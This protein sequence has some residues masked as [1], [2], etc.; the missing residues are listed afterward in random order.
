MTQMAER[1]YVVPHP[2]PEVVSRVV[3]DIEVTDIQTLRDTECKFGTVHE[4]VVFFSDDSAR[5]R[6]LYT[7]LVPLANAPL[8]TIDTAWFMRLEGHNDATANTLMSEGLTVD[9]LGPEMLGITDITHIPTAIS[10]DAD[11]AAH[12]ALNDHEHAAGIVDAS[13]TIG[14]GSSRGA[15][16]QLGYASLMSGRDDR[17]VE[18]L[19][20]VDVVL[21]NTLGHD[22]LSAAE[23]VAYLAQEAV[24]GVLTI[25]QNIS[26][27]ELMHSVTSTPLEL[28]QAAAVWYSLVDCESGRFAA[29]LPADTVAHITLFAQSRLNHR[30]LWH[31]AFDKYENVT[32]VDHNNEYH[33]SMLKR[34]YVDASVKRVINASLLVSQGENI[35]NFDLNMSLKAL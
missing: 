5:Q 22:H 35:A 19:E 7:P 29:N 12:V 25:A 3:P 28:L 33:L 21:H 2:E 18:Y 8:V 14:T 1:L 6:R 16:E 27:K 23:M 32:V 10:V 13:H 34:K 31:Q 9:M 20:L 24:H 30:A 11:I 17:Q 26:P 15:I 4:Q